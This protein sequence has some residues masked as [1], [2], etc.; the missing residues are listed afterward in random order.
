MIC[1]RGH[2]TVRRCGRSKDPAAA[3][4]IAS[5]IISS[6]GIKTTNLP[7]V[8]YA[9]G[10]REDY[11]SYQSADQMVASRYTIAP[12]SPQNDVKASGSD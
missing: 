9:V 8:T 5:I 2:F 3:E 7:F 1:M 10:G 6:K 4:E 11:G 12:R